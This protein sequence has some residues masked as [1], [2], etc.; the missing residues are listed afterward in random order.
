MVHLSF[1]TLQHTTKNTLIFPA[2]FFACTQQSEKIYRW[3]W[4]PPPPPPPTLMANEPPSSSA[5]A[6][7]RTDFEMAEKALKQGNRRAQA[8]THCHRSRCVIL[9]CAILLSSAKVRCCCC[10]LQGQQQQQLLSLYG[11]FPAVYF[12]LTVCYLSFFLFKID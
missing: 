11:A 9:I 2:C 6:N 3:Q 8:H 5:V 4:S 12:L 1:F 7:G 10:R